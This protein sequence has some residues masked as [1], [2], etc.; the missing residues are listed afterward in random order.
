MNI[1]D[2]M[3]Q[4]SLFDNIKKTEHPTKITIDEFISYIKEGKWKKEVNKA[5]AELKTAE[6]KE[7]RGRIKGVLPNATMSGYF[8]KRGAK[9]L[10]KHSGFILIDIDNLSSN[11]NKVFNQLKDDIYSYAI[12]RSVSNTGLGVLIKID[13]SKHTESFQ[14]IE[15]YY[16]FKYNLEAD[17]ACK[18]VSRTRY[19]SYDPKLYE[20]KEAKTFDNFLINKEEGK[21]YAKLDTT[22]ITNSLL[23][24]LEYCKEHKIDITEGYN[25]WLVTALSLASSLGEDGRTLFHQ[26]SELNAEYSPERCE[27]KYDNCMETGNGSVTIGTLF[28]ILQEAGVPVN[29]RNVNK[30]NDIKMVIDYLNATYKIRENVI[31]NIIECSPVDSE[32][33]EG[34]NVDDI[35]I[36]LKLLNFKISLIDLKSLI[37]SE[38][39]SMKYNPVEEYFKSL[40]WDNGSHIENLAGYFTTDNDDRFAMQLK[41][42]LV[43]SIACAI[44]TDTFNKHCIVLHSNKQ[45]LGKTSFWRWL[46]PEPFRQRYYF[47]GHLDPQSKDSIMYLGSSFFINLDELASLGKAGINHLKAMLT[48]NGTMIRLPFQPQPQWVSRIATFV[49]S[50]NDDDFLIDINNVRWIIVR[51]EDIDFAYS[52]ELN[53]NQIWAEAYAEYMDGF[54]YNLTKDEIDQNEEVANIYKAIS[55]EQEL[56]MKYFEPSDHREGVFI[57]NADIASML[58]DLNPSIRVNIKYI[59]SETK[60]AG[61]VKTK[62]SGKWGYW[63][64]FTDDYRE[65]YENRIGSRALQF[66]KEAKVETNKT[67]KIGGETVP[68]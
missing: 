37:R 58:Q 14:S 10:I 15:A 54:D 68:F 1:K 33:Y 8:K 9:N 3:N 25:N 45:N 62:R 59:A 26:F 57:Q 20:N 39:V 30:A 43:R 12:F 11:I 53:V 29:T 38:E 35:Y 42:M 19:V 32:E 13:P 52:E 5:R 46:C 28:H 44:E 23:A 65:D 41:K 48:A 17:T 2:N 21:K 64:T 24:A 16:Q 50:T 6:T 66:E 56:I 34:I 27:E 60:K 4:I 61:F 47:E 51:V 31:S 67:V 22:V 7:E 49:G 55:T 36:K 63:V 18:D 40:E